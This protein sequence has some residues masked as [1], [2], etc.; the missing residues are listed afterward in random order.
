MV[1]PGTLSQQA[2]AVVVEPLAAGRRIAV[3]GDATAGLDAILLDQGA[4]VVSLFDPD[5][6]RA[7]AASE[8]APMGA[9]VH[10]YIDEDLRPADV[11]IV[12]DLGIF[13]D[14]ADVVARARRIVG[15]YGVAVFAA[16]NAEARAQRGD[17]DDAREGSR[18]FDYYDLFDLIAGEF[19]TVKM[20]AQLPFYGVA[21]ME[22]GGDDDE[23]AGVGVNVDTRL[24]EGGRIPEGFVVVASQGTDGALHPYSIVELPSSS[25]GSPGSIEGLLPPDE[26]LVAALAD[27]HTR[28]EV[29]TGELEAM[30]VRATT[31]EGA[32]EG[33][34]RLEH[35]VAERFEHEVTERTR[36][37]AAAEQELA[38]TGHAHAKE[39]ALAADAY[40]K[41]LALAADAH[42]KDLALTADAHAKELARLE[43]GLRERSQ[44]V[45]V[46][47]RE[48]ARH[49]Q[50]VRDLVS[51]LDDAAPRGD[52]QAYDVQANVDVVATLH[53]RLDALAL[54]LARREGEAHASAWKI[55]ELE[56]RL[57]Q[58]SAKAAAE[59]TTEPALDAQVARSGILEEVDALR[60]ALV[61]EHEARVRAESGEELIH[62][63]AEIERLGALLHPA[64]PNEGGALPS[65][66]LGGGVG[67]KAGKGEQDISR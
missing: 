13:A 51:A 58:T 1:L 12:T 43:E 50:M 30:R 6:A 29:L 41:D 64:A 16:A 67:D 14:P 15:E 48:I 35:E 56:R 27:A 36:R 52:V 2:L 40:A 55:D 28:A 45:R 4:R 20:V 19:G 32:L 44:A 31:A 37:G 62:A 5:T 21:L 42:A 8:R 22:L 46:L 34:R 24:A 63:R 11:A 3:F 25:G 60:Q 18:A 59:P 54:D 65:G 7:R 39:L 33:L 49:D 26:T 61:Q 17:G 53:A 38:L 66:G 23:A 9:T 57:A 47:E 10:P